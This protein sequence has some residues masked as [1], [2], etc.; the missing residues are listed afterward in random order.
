MFN[1]TS[2]G[3]ILWD[4]Y[5]DKKRLG[6]APFN[7]IF[8]IKKIIDNANFIS[9]IGNDKEGLEIFHLLSKNN[10]EM[11]NIFI[12]E[13]HP[14][15]KVIVTLDGNKTPHFKMSETASFDF[16]ELTENALK[17][18]ENSDL[19]Y[20]G[21][22]TSRSEKSRNTL[23]K[24]LNNF[25]KKFFCDLNLRHDFYSVDFIKL[26]LQKTNV[27][28][29]NEHELEKLKVLINLNSNEDFAI[30]ELINKYNID[31]IAL[32]LGEKGAK[33]FT[34]DEM[35]F[36]QQPEIEI[37]DT[38]GAGDA[39]SA[40]LCLGYLYNISLDKINLLANQFASKVCLIEGAFTDDEKFYSD[41]RK[42]FN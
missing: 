23:T 8:H 28:K 32:T 16:L 35:N 34:K 21:T 5:P 3:E 30:D 19:I 14:T 31:L 25:N 2:I 18:I 42:F 17:T 11:K 29:I 24:I 20:F 12:D 37:I 1:I 10:F 6:G 22:F 41:F 9:S 4:I 36:Y 15:G 39:F 27:L 13:V 33:L 26:A 40:I 7:F 38:L